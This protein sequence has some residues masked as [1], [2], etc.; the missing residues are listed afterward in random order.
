M[1]KDTSLNGLRGQII[2]SVHGR[3]LG[4]DVDGFLVGHLGERQT[5][6]GVSSAG[7][8]IVSTSVA[9]ALTN[10]GVSLVGASAASGT[11]GY[12]MTSPTPGCEKILFVPTTGYAVVTLTTDSTGAGAG[13][14]LCSTA[15]VTST[16]QVI[17]FAGKGGF[18]RLIGL[19]TGL[20]GLAGWG[21]NV[22]GA[23]SSAASTSIT[24]TP[25]VTFS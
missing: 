13:A 12:I 7:S 21:P 19:T 16:Y 14:M 9:T 25:A 1:P 24:F 11:T 10:Y 20:W 23:L 5:V 15:S 4:L 2:T 18:V 8:T 22:S 3:R 6:A 17:T